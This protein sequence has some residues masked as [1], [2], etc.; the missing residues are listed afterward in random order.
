MLGVNFG[1]RCAL[2]RVAE[3]C[4]TISRQLQVVRYGQ[5][6]WFA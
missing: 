5:T 2:G 6:E 1:L 4:V 3:D